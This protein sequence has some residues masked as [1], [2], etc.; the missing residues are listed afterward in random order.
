MLKYLIAVLSVIFIALGTLYM[1]FST[2]IFIDFRPNAPISTAFRAEDDAIVFQDSE[3]TFTPLLLRGVEVTPSI[4]GKMSRNFYVGMYDYLRW[5]GYIY[6]MGANTIYASNTM[7]SDFYNALYKFNT[8]SDRPLLLLQ[9]VD[10]HDYNSLTS[11][12]K[13]T[14]DIIHGSRVNLLDSI[15]FELFRSDVSPWVVGFLVGSEWNPDTITFMNHFDPVLA[16]SF[17]GE[18]FSSADSSSRFEV[19]LAQVMD[20]AT[21]YETK[22]YKVQRPIGFISNPTIDFLEYEWAYAVQLG[23]HVQLNSENIIPTQSMGAGTFASYR[24]FYFVDD[25]AKYLAPNQ[26]ETLAPILESL[27]Q[28]CIFDGYLD[29]L[30]RYHNMPVIATGFGFS[31]SRAPHIMERSPLTEQDQGEALA[32]TAMQIEEAGWGG[33]FISTWQDTWDRRAWNTAFS[34]DPW[35]YHYWHN[36]QSVD[37]GYGLIAFEPGRYSRPV[38]IDGN[39]NDWNDYHLVHEDRGISIY[40]QYSTQGLYLLIRGDAINPTNTIYLPIDVTP[41]SGTSVFNDLEFQRPSDFLLILSGEHESRLL[42]NRRYHATYQRFY[43]EIAG[44]NPFT[45]VP[46]RWESEFVPI[47]LALQNTLMVDAHTFAWLTDEARE[48]RRLK[49]WDTGVL[50]HGIGDP[51][52]LYFNSLTDFSFGENLVEIRLPWMLLNFYDPSLMQVHDDYFERF[53]VEGQRISAIYIGAATE[54]GTVPMSPIP[55]RGWRNYVVFHERLKQSYF[56]MQ[57]NW[58]D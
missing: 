55:L 42:V 54:G 18:F 48:L 52:S 6:E 12:L 45:A 36:L 7:D 44:I 25:F 41:R 39:T 53:G 17:Q 33:S 10:G 5:F 8:T 40:A 20:S 58:R 56:I 34:S 43:E 23:K 32:V 2:S 27:D 28:S 57:K 47:T 21:A 16:D 15:G 30:A 1:H 3:G 50:T 13:E 4:P 29:L 19:M 35:R 51:D 46:P 14:I 9:G 26:Q 38:L 49:Y 37:Q 11:T 22:R 24:L 31:S